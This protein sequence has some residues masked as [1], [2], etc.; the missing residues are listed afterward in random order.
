MFNILMM[1]YWLLFPISI[2]ISTIAMAAGIGGAVFFSPL[3]VL[4]YDLEL[5]FA[6]TLG[7]FIE[8]FSFG[9]GIYAYSKQKLIDFSLAISVLKYSVPAVVAGSLSAIFIPEF[10]IKPIF[11]LLLLFIAANMLYPEKY[12]RKFQKTKIEKHKSEKGTITYDLPKRK[13]DLFAYPTIGGYF[14]GLLSVG[15]G[16]LNEYL[17]LQKMKIK[18]SLA[19]GTSIF[20]VAVSALIGASLRFFLLG[21]LA[22]NFEKAVPFLSFIVPG[23]LV[24]GQLGMLLSK[25]F[26]DP[27]L[28]KRFVGLIILIAGLM[29]LAT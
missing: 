28:M 12:V 23:V 27:D 4:L 25:K 17:F 18:S 13:R 11:S 15:I 3:I 24:G 21:D 19:S 14:V 5:G 29:V 10:I 26:L 9:S 20:I 7:L 16:E 2:V 8:I 6:L 1:D 22:M